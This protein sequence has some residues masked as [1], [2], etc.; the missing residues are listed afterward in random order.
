MFTDHDPI[1]MGMFDLGHRG[2]FDYTQ[3]ARAL[4]RSPTERLD[5][6][7][8]WR[9]F[10]KEALQDAQLRQGNHPATRPGSG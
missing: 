5:H 10:V 4:V 3:L 2:S 8:E 1:P 6:H 9:L 7:E